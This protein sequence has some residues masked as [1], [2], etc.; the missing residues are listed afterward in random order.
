MLS[1]I[2]LCWENTWNDISR[3]LISSWNAIKTTISNMKMW[4]VNA[5]QVVYNQITSMFAN[6]GTFFSNVWDNIK[7]T[8]S[9][10]GTSIGDAIS[11]AVK[12]GINGVISLIERTIN[13]AI[14]LINNAIGV[15]NL[16]PGVNVG[17]IR[18]LNLPRLAE[19]GYFKANQPTLAI[20][21][22]NKT[23]SEIVSPVG[24][25]EDAVENVLNKRGLGDNA[26]L[27]KLLKIIISIL[28]SLD[29][30][31]KIYLDGYEV[32]KRLEKIRKKKEFATNGG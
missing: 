1:A 15:I 18:K 24:K 3:F 32:N 14:N 4:I 12:S 8:F 11:N 26:E 20:V 6:I 31:P 22:D 29:L 9:R 5:F 16:I 2:K 21:G 27:V 10:L 17:K 7:N 28:Q 30:D 25:I 13:K 19:G 23:Q